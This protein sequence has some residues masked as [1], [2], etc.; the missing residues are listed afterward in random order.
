MPPP[1]FQ[2]GKVQESLNIDFGGIQ[3]HF[4]ASNKV[5]KSSLGS[6]PLKGGLMLSLSPIRRFWD[7]NKAKLV[8]KNLSDVSLLACLMPV[9]GA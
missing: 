5:K 9:S 7:A 2:L 6:V 1:V 4:F 8:C 3:E